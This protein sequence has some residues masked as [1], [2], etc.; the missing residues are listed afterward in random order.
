MLVPHCARSSSSTLIMRV[1]RACSSCGLLMRAPHVRFSWAL[2]L[3][4]LPPHGRYFCAFF[5][6][7]PHLP[8]PHAPSSS[9]DLLRRSSSCAL[10]IV[11]ASRVRSSQSSLLIGH[12]SH[13]R[14]M[15]APHVQSSWALFVRIAHACFSSCG[16]SC[17][18]LI[19]CVPHVYSSCAIIFVRFLIVLAPH[20]VRSLFCALL[21]VFAPYRAL[22]SSSTLIILR[23]P[24]AR[25]S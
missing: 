5:M 19:V 8:A 1:Y 6:R 4:I 2:L 14:S 3:R 18:L 7:P 21:F 9:C 12:S 23:A 11:R 13:P 10:F 22:S 15:H 16:S 20:C 24:H 25:L 17:A